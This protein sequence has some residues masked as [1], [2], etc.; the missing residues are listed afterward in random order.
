VPQ[1]SSATAAPDDSLRPAFLHVIWWRAVTSLFHNGPRRRHCHLMP[2]G[3]GLI[4]IGL[5]VS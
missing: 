4:Q 5:N 1:F 2:T 3:T